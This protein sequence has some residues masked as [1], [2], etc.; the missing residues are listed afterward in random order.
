LRSLL[1]EKL[2]IEPRSIHAYIIG[3]HGDS[4]VAVWSSANI[5]GVPLKK[6]SSESGKLDYE[7]LLQKVRRAAPDIVAR[8]GYTSYAIASSVEMI[9]RAIMRDEKKVMPVSTMTNGQYGITGIYLSLPCVVGGEGVERVIELPLD[10]K[11]LE[12]LRASAD[13]LLRK[14]QTLGDFDTTSRLV[15]ASKFQI[16]NL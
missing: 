8:K 10:E 13:V 9:S 16:C 7:E 4:E 2:K 5:A 15:P 14:F 6:F 3:E 1:A 12:G 11:E